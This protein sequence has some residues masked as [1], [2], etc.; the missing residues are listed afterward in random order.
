MG[1][2]R[3]ELSEALGALEPLELF[4]EADSMTSGAPREQ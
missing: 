2:K 1:M 4:C 3:Y